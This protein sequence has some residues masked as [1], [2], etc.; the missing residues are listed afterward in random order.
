MSG[1]AIKSA[2]VVATGTLVA[3]A[4]RLVGIYVEAGATGGTLILRDGGAGGTILVEIPT[5]AAASMA[6]IPVPEPGI[7]FDTD[8]HATLT[9]A[10]GVM[11]FY[12]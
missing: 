11:V 4:C 6:Y 8:I 5:P 3:D 2:E 9:N 1:N 7:D 10:A 12:K